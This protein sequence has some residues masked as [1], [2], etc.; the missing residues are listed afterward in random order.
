[1]GWIKRG[2]GEVGRARHTH[3]DWGLGK[4]LYALYNL[5][6]GIFAKSFTTT[7]ISLETDLRRCD[8]F[9][10]QRQPILFNGF[11]VAAFLKISH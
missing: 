1:M 3:R 10:S 5:Y 6:A 11:C 2:G 4:N 9:F 7:K 8:A